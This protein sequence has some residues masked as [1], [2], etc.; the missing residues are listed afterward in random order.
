MRGI[1][2][3]ETPAF[4]VP[5]HLER[6]QTLPSVSSD[7]FQSMA[8]I[9]VFRLTTNMMYCVPSVTAQFTELTLS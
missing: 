5:R 7:A 3:Q 9:N 8:Y 1:Q 4:V 6:C 2:A